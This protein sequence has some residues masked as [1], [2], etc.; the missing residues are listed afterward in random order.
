MPSLFPKCPNPKCP[1]SF[2]DY[3]FNYHTRGGGVTPC[4]V[5]CNFCNNTFI[6]DNQNCG[7]CVDRL[8]C[9]LFPTRKGQGP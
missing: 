6:I 7:D 4:R 8:R 9:L 5:L 3:S 1:S 2:G